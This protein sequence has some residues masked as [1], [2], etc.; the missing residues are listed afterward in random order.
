MLGETVGV[1]KASRKNESEWLRGKRVVWL[2][3]LR[4]LFLII[5]DYGDARDL[6]VLPLI[7]KFEVN[8]I[9]TCFRSDCPLKIHAE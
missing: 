5:C 7:I 4:L 9:F 8:F 2:A 1:Q 3:D 6:D